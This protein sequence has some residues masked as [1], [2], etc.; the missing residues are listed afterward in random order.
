MTRIV[1]AAV[2]H[3][4]NAP[5]S[6][7]DVEVMA[8]TS[9]QVLVKISAVGLCHSD[10]HAINGDLPV[11]LPCVP[12][13]EGAGV[14]EEIGPGVTTVSQGD[15]VVLCGMASC[16]KCPRCLEGRAYFCQ[17]GFDALG[18]TLM[19][20]TTRLIT[21]SG[22]E[23]YHFLCQ[24][25]FAEY[26]VV[27]ERQLVKVRKDA[28]LSVACLLACGASTGLGAALNCA[29][30][31]PGTRVAVFGCG[32]VGLS[33]IM[34]ANL[35]NAERIIA[36]DVLP[37]KLA[38]ARELGATDTVD[39][40][41]EDPLD[42]I[43][44]ISD[45]KGID[46]AFEAVGNMELTNQAI[47][48]VGSGGMVVLLGLPPQDA[49]MSIEAVQLMVGKTITFAP[50]GYTRFASDVPRFLN[51]YMAGKLPLD[52]LLTRTY[53]LDEIN[54]AIDALEKGEVIRAAITF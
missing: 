45:G 5:L 23:L 30:V 37:N 24:S 20:G 11:P 12:G 54:E 6:V 38:M 13:H 41:K 42:L 22:G 7:E 49:V 25:S 50:F 44:E 26:A 36:V 52:K 16:G 39:A 14:V 31:E 8:P 15:H 40:S 21:R 19:D 32:G 46:Y 35:M 17:F 43:G 1:K 34:G 9:G 10:L 18:G 33:A 29:R 51:L 27:N 4:I 48:S 53:K 3:E 28:P 47:A 2:L